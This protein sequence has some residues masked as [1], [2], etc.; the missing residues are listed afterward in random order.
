MFRWEMLREFSPDFIVHWIAYLPLIFFCLSEEPHFWKSIVHAYDNTICRRSSRATLLQCEW[1]HHLALRAAA[2][3]HTNI[4]P[5]RKKNNRR[6]KILQFPHGGFRSLS[7][8]NGQG[9]SNGHLATGWVSPLSRCWKYELEINGSCELTD[10]RH[11]EKT[12][13]VI[14]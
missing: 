14:S 3:L 13:W 8:S 7:S 2:L 4:W 10:M 11:F 9:I 1:N 6:V 5:G 12:R